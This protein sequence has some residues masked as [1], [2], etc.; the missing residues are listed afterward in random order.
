M[1]RGLNPFVNCVGVVW[2]KAIYPGAQVMNF[3]QDPRSGSHEIGAS[4]LQSCTLTFAATAHPQCAMVLNVSLSNDSVTRTLSSPEES[5]DM[6]TVGCSPTLPEICN[7]APDLLPISI[8]G[9]FT[10]EESGVQK[11]CH[12]FLTRGAL[13]RARPFERRDEPNK[14]ALT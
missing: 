5:D 12:R 2:V 7:I 3:R 14:T 6:T 8:F 13:R 4:V 10:D 11:G 9:S 1:A